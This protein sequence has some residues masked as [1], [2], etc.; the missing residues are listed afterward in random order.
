[1]G[2]NI[3]DREKSFKYIKIGSFF[4]GAF[5]LFF[6]AILSIREVSF[7]KGTYPITVVFEFAE[8]LRQS[9]PVRYCGVDVGEVQRVEVK[10]RDNKPLVFV[11]IKVKDEMKIPKHSF[12]FINSLSLFGEKYLEITP[13]AV[14]TGYLKEEDTV[15][16]ISPI[17]LFNVFATFTKTMEEVRSFVKEGKIK[18]SFENILANVEGISLE[19]KGLFEDMRNKQGTVGRLLYDDSLY[20]TTEEFIKDIKA[21]PWKLLH[22]P[23]EPRRKKR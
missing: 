4:L 8:G 17:P 10:D 18:T 5:F 20:Q 2:R 23:K 13:P 3:W 16:G 11:R 19:I 1:M 21:H 14:P 7:L 22:K 6:I 9:S 12:F 15:D